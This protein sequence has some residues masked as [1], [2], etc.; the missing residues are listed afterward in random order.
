MIQVGLLVTPE[1]IWLSFLWCKI[2]I[3]VLYCLFFGAA[4]ALQQIIQAYSR[5]YYTVSVVTATKQVNST[6]GFSFICTNYFSQRK[7]FSI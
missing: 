7:T 2:W 6:R 4:Y 3:L 1:F 5:I